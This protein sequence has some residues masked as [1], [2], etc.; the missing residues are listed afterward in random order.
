MSEN[1]S[2]NIEKEL[3]KSIIGFLDKYGEKL[4]NGVK[5][6][7]KEASHETRLNWR[8]GYE[9]YLDCALQR[10]SYVKTFFSFNRSTYLYDFYVPLTLYCQGIV[11]ERASIDELISVSKRPPNSFD[12]AAEKNRSV[13]IKA[14]GGSGKTMIMRHLFVETLLKTHYVPIFIELRELNNSDLSLFQFIIKK[15]HDNKFE[16]DD[17][18]IIKALEAGHFIIFLDGFDEVEFNKRRSVISGIQYITEKFEETF[19][20]VSSRPDDSF[21]GW[22]TFSIWSVEPLKLHQAVELIEKTEENLERKSNFIKALKEQLFSAQNSFLSNPLLLLIM[23][24]T[25]KNSAEIPQRLSNFYDYAYSTL[26]YRHD[27]Q[28]GDFRR[29]KLS[30]LGIEEFRNSFSAFCF[31]TYFQ[32][33]FT[34]SETQIFDFFVQSQKVSGIQFSKEKFL[35]DS[36]QAVCLL[37]RDGLDISFS[38]RSF[39]EYFAAIYVFSQIK[40]K[41]IQQRIIEQM[42]KNNRWET[43]HHVLFEICPELVES[44][45]FIPTLEQV[46]KV[47]SYSEGEIT[48]I[49]HKTFLKMFIEKIIF[50]NRNIDV[51]YNQKYTS[52][53]TFYYLVFDNYLFLM[54]GPYHYSIVEVI[55]EE[56]FN[57]YKSESNLSEVLISDILENEKIY[58]QFSEG[59]HVFSKN[60]LFDFLNLK[61]ILI[62][63]RDEKNSILEELFEKT[64]SE[65]SFQSILHN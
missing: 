56:F 59:N 20:V 26:F 13:V 31:L 34:F 12:I 5:Y 10:Y 37:I 49:Q 44:Y 48:E 38:H 15:L 41:H 3:P 40:D 16:F 63:K 21:Y 22:N 7:Y 32:S 50:I 52:L 6:V 58:K 2:D 53:T 33:K 35:V 8:L 65:S 45:F 19:V 9:K 29:E 4:W 61:H 36:I 42:F 11:L 17:N 60:A 28:K 18:Y 25:Y 47:I 54:Q 62:N 30:D 39:Q 27:A 14:T 55:R 1:K 23:F 64:S 51:G 24:I 57:A 46:R 43:F